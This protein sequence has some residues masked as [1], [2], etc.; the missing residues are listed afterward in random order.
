MLKACGE[1]L[2]LRR[3]GMSAVKR[4]LV[5]AWLLATISDTVFHPPETPS[6]ALHVASLFYS[7][8]RNVI[9]YKPHSYNISKMLTCGRKQR[10]LDSVK[11]GNNGMY[12]YTG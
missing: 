2:Q 3:G 10:V 4:G 6:H 9:A 11:Y 1:L 5:L 12:R 8:W 7:P